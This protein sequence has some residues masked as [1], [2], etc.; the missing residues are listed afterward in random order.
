MIRR[1]PITKMKNWILCD[2]CKQAMKQANR[3]ARGMREALKN[4]VM[5]RLFID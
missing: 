3:R 4:E 2:T 1:E 5:Y